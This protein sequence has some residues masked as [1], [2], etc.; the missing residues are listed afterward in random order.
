MQAHDRTQQMNDALLDK[1]NGYTLFDV[2]LLA[3][4]LSQ[5]IPRHTVVPFVPLLVQG[6][7]L[8]SSL[9]IGDMEWFERMQPMV[10]PSL[11]TVFDLSAR[12]DLMEMMRAIGPR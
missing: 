9:K 6:W 10:L 8:L 5:R 1:L 7:E 4:Y 3:G 11:W 12:D 2:A